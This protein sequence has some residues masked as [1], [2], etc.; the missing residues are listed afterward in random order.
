MSEKCELLDK[1]GFFINYK[2]NSEVVKQGWINMFCN[3]LESSENC[4]RKKVRK[5]T[6]SPPADNMAPTGTMLPE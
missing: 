6:G 4:K 1:C 5:S 3:R 2:K